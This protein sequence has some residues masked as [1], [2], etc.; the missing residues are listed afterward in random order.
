M[1]YITSMLVLRLDV[2]INRSKHVM[3]NESAECR[4]L[5]K[6]NVALMLMLFLKVS[7]IADL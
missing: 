3:E 2:I 4:L 5:P 6:T 1:V 7:D